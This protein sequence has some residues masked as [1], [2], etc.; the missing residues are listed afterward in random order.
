MRDRRGFF[1]EEGV[2]RGKL[3]VFK[4]GRSTNPVFRVGVGTEGER[5]W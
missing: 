3:I 4:V 1:D 5:E 2:R